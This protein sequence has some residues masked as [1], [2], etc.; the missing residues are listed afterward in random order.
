MPWIKPLRKGHHDAVTAVGMKR[1]LFGCAV[2]VLVMAA[3][4]TL[5]PDAR[6]EPP[7]VDYSRLLDLIRL[8]DHREPL[9]AFNAFEDRFD[10]AGHRMFLRYFNE[11]PNLVQKIKSDLGAA[12]L[13][14]KLGS[15][16]KRL[17]F[18]P[19]NRSEY[20]D[21]YYHYCLA[22]IDFTLREARLE[23]P[24]A[25]LVTLASEVPSAFEQDGITVFLVHNLAREFRG[26][27]RF[28]AEKA[29]AE[30][31]VSVSSRVFIGEIGSYTSRLAF[32]E[33]GALD[34]VHASYTI[35]Q[36]SAS[37]PYN[38]LIVPLEETLH[39]GLRPY[40][41]SAIAA[42]LQKEKIATLQGAETLVQHWTAVE[43]AAVGGLVTSIF[44][45]LAERMSLEVESGGIESAIQARTTSGKYRFL[46][47]G[48]ALVQ[49]L[50]ESDILEM[51][52]RDPVEFYRRLLEE[53]E[54]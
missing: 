43:E 51:Y 27:Y 1:W 37:A 9:F 39:I 18:V 12:R 50:G 53:E 15:L 31:E 36:N 28:F 46:R 8:E 41:E 4:C 49:N 24:Y 21:L 35:W 29:D 5:V 34:F 7:T 2:A 11:H 44:P 17:L 54:V 48:I 13:K 25:S 16:E 26:T 22:A 23:N 52:R 3:V 42:D 38:A 30:V 20:A 32:G 19:E 10:P 14:W 33:N 47:S 40:T 6:C 45:R